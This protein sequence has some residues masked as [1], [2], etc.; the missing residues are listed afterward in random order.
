MDDVAHDPVLS[1]IERGDRALIGKAPEDDLTHPWAGNVIDL[2]PVGALLSKDSLN[3]ARAWELDRSASVCP[4]CSQGCNMIVETRDNQ[5]VR[6]RPRP[7]EAVNKFFMC[8]HGRLNYRWMNRPD[9]VESPLVRQNGVL[10][11]AD[12]E[13]A[14]RAAAQTLA[15]KRAFVL[16]SPNLSNEALYLLS[17]L[18]KKAGGSGAFRVNQGPEAPL[19]GV[20][21][22]ALRPDRAANVRGAELLGFARSDA[23]LSAMQAGDVLVVADEELAGADA[24]AAAK[25]GAVIVI[26]TTLP[27]WA[28]HGA[29]V[30]LPISNCVEEEGTFTNLRGR[31]QRFLQAKAAPGIARPSYFVLGDLLAAMG[32]GQGYW[33]ASAVFDAL[34]AGRPEFGGMSYDTLALKG[35]APA[36]AMAGA[37]A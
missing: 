3:K 13:I 28:R 9:R 18:V 34:A 27:A 23:P 16:A 36:G 2:C 19:P 12:W 37:S 22:L 15:G 33:T 29:N 31:V 25:A 14:L 7:N 8:D 1:V 4:N 6:L 35:A 21:D 5:V 30:V 11:V 17:R 24:G 26:G 10:A 32:E 20:E